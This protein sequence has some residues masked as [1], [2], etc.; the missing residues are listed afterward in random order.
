MNFSPPGRYV[1]M[2][3]AHHRKPFE[4]A[5]LA[6]PSQTFYN[7]ACFSFYYHMYGAEVGSLKVYTNDTLVWQLD[8]N[9]GNQWIKGQFFMKSGQIVKVGDWNSLFSCW[10]NGI[11]TWCAGLKFSKYLYLNNF[12]T[13]VHTHVH[14]HTHNQ[15]QT[16]AYIV[17]FVSW[18]IA[19]C[20]YTAM[21]GFCAA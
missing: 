11:L 19:S 9:Q 8:G 5:R 12:R 7:N 3:T 13:S 6:T 14:R 18:K 21:R 15:G 1:Y 17:G 20:F 10:F 2:S 16:T 4:F